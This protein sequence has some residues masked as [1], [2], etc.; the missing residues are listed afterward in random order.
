[1]NVVSQ[2]SRVT[3]LEVA[4][5][6]QPQVELPVRSHFDFGVYQRVGLIPAETVCTGAVHL[7][8]GTFVLAKGT[9]LMDGEVLHA[10]YSVT[11]LPG[12]KR[13]MYAV[14]DCVV[15]AVIES[16][17]QTEAEAEATLVVPTYQDFNNL[18]EVSC[19]SSLPGP[20]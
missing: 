3:A 1:M 20:G 13:A 4:I 6:A 16:D 7:C 8:A 15:I 5:K 2:D 12:T 11:T 17:V 9:L 10:P 19:H 18:L 14:T